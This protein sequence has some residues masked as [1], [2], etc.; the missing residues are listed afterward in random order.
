MSTLP[1]WR[2]RRGE[3]GAND[4]GE[5]KKEFSLRYSK[6]KYATRM[7]IIHTP[8]PEPRRAA[9]NGMKRPSCAACWLPSL[10]PH[11][12][13]DPCLSKPPPSQQPSSRAHGLLLLLLLYF[14]EAA[15]LRRPTVVVIAGPTAVGKSAGPRAVL[16]A[17]RAAAWRIV[18]ADS[19]RVYRHRDVGQQGVPGGASFAVRHHLLDVIDPDERFAGRFV[20]DADAAIAE[21]LAAGGEELHSQCQQTQSQQTQSANAVP[22]NAV[23]VGVPRGGGGHAALPAVVRTRPPDAPSTPE[24][25][26]AV[27]ALLRPFEE[28]ATGRAGWR[29]WPTSTSVPPPTTKRAAAVA[30]AAA[31]TTVIALSQRAAELN[32]NDWYRLARALEV[33]MAAVSSSSSSQMTRGRR[34]RGERR[35]SRRRRCRPERAVRP[36]VLLPLPG[37]PAGPL[38]AHRRAL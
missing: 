38:R 21:I 18:S 15:P 16:G 11:D 32:A 20:R 17:P 9:K 10:P 7:I 13:G 5:Q 1:R 24:T 28:P 19:V 2:E 6:Y 4:R 30:L 37:G 25:A 3:G 22:A 26:A 12:K 33:A 29:S 27:A 31:A 34:R 23:A 14:R 8:L 35:P 36:A